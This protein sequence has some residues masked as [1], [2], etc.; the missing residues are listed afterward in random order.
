MGKEL[1]ADQLNGE[2]CLG[3]T[4]KEL[5]IKFKIGIEFWLLCELRGWGFLSLLQ[6]VT[7][8]DN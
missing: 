1:S 5:A 8:L 7:I 6:R 2:Y 3:Q 4:G